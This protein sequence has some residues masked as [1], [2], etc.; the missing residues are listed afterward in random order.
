MKR[1]LEIVEDGKS[2][3]VYF[4]NFF[5]S[6]QLLCDLKEAGFRATGTV[7]ENR[8][9]RCPLP[10]NKDFKKEQRGAYDYR[11]D[12]ANDILVVKWQDNNVVS[13]A[14]NHLS[15]DPLRPVEQRVKG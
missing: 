13:V 8:L 1:L 14:S 3:E 12:A 5:T 9:A 11:F 10:S 7:R 2:H 6:H 15:L 4:D